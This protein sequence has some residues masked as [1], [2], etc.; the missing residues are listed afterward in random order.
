[1]R[2]VLGQFDQATE[3]RLRFAKQLGVNGVLLNTPRLPGEKRWE[4]MD[5]VRLRGTVEDYGLCLEALE[6]V[7]LKFYDR[8]MLGLAERDEQIANYQETIRN[9]GRAG[10][11]ILGYHWMPNSVWRT[12]ATTLGRG[13]A[14]VTSFD[15]DLVRQAPL[16]HGREFP[17]DE[18]WQNYEIFMKAVLPVAEEF[19]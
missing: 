6:N 15:L 14:H 9:V 10:I 13:G 11:P 2:V 3:E 5:L 8:A 18:M 7:P 16:T 1:M 19:N 17:E 4:Y 12:S